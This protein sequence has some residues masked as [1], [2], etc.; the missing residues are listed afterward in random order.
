[1]KRLKYD[2]VKWRLKA[3]TLTLRRKEKIMPQF[4]LTQKYAKDCHINTLSDPQLVVHPLDD[5]FIDVIRIN[6]K[7]IAMATH[8]QSTFTFFIPYATVSKAA[9]IPA[10]IGELLKEFLYSHGLLEWAEGVDML[11][12]ETTRFCKTAN[13]KILGHMNDFRQCAKA[14][15]EHPPNCAPPINWDQIANK[16]NN[17]PVNFSADNQYIFPIKLLAKLIGHSLK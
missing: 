7:K 9:A 6:R 14:Y 3:G 10:Y 8:A 1:M 17:M 4:R 2:L 15:A 12:S 5:W 13:R 11:F 16:I